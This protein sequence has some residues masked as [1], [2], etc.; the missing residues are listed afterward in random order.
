MA[1]VITRH[2]FASG[3]REVHRVVVLGISLNIAEKQR[4]SLISGYAA[5]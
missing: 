4:L 2:D 3:Y 5:R 1:P